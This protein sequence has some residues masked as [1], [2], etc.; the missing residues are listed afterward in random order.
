MFGYFSN[1]VAKYYGSNKYTWAFLKL[2][3][4]QLQLN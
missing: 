3:Q 1:M 2:G 4:L